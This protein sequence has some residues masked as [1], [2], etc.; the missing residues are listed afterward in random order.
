MANSSAILKYFCDHGSRILH[1]FPC[2]NGSY[3]GGNCAMECVPSFV[4]RK[5]DRF[6]VIT[7]RPPGSHWAYMYDGPTLLVTRTP[8]TLFA[9]D[10]DRLG[11]CEVDQALV[12]T[13]LGCSP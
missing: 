12:G 2:L 9:M 8:G 3:A 11:T 1:L 7:T 4:T 13:G 5:L 10:L 6:S